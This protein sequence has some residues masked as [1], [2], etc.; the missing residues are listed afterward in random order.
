[1]PR[2][3]H[4]SD[5]PD[6]ARFEPRPVAVPSERAPGREWLN[7]PLVWAIEDA[8]QS[9][10]LFPRECPRIL[11][12]PTETARAEDRA[13]WWGTR[14]CRAIAHVEWDWFERLKTGAIWRYE[15]PVATF[16]DLNDA[17]MWVSRE[18]VTPIDVVRIDDLPGA[19]RSEDVELRVMDSLLPLKRVWET[20]L[21]ASGVR[22]RNAAGWGL[23]PGVVRLARRTDADRF[24]E[25][26]HSAGLL[27]RTAPG[28]EWIAEHGASPADFYWP[29][30][31]AQTVWVVEGEAGELNGF[32]AGEAVGDVMHIWELAVT[33]PAQALGLGRRLMLAACERARALGLAAITLTTFRDVAWNAPFYARLGYRVLKGAEVDLRLS[34]ILRGEIE[35][36]LPS[37]RRCAMRLELAG[38]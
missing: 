24:P 14:T 18:A 33:G 4:F 1:M 21:H 30:I 26:E 28:L 38:E 17:G 11:L 25:I 16:E 2:L 23:A 6:I 5:D 29:H 13:A 7:G 15:L 10:Y 8:R 34:A 35:R 31:A 36:G 37:E 12:W 20:S 27:F 19:L 32:V 22:L 3:F 9:L